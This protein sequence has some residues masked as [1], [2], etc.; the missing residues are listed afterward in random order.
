MKSRKFCIACVAVVLALSLCFAVACNHAH[1]Y[2][3]WGYNATEHWKECPDDG[4]ID[5][6]S[7]SA[8]NFG[9]DGKCT[10]GAEKASGGSQGGGTGGGGGSVSSG[11]ADDIKTD[12]TRPVSEHQGHN[13]VW[14]HDAMQHWK[15]CNDDNVADMTTYAAHTFNDGTCECG[16]TEHTDHDY[17]VWRHNASGHWKACSICG[18]AESATVTPHDFTDKKVCECGALEPV[19]YV[20]LEPD[21][22][23]NSPY[24]LVGQFGGVDRWTD[25]RGI[26]MEQDGSNWTITKELKV[27]D[28]WKIKKRGV[29]WDDW[30]IKFTATKNITAA[31]G[32]VGA[33]DKV[34]FKAGE[35]GNF[36]VNYNCT[37]TISHNGDAS[38]VNILVKSA[39]DVPENPTVYSYTFHI[40][41]PNWSNVH[42]HLW[43]PI[44]TG[45]WNDKPAMHNDGNGWWSY[46]YT[47]YEPLDET[48]EQGMVITNGTDSGQADWT[49]RI[50]M[51]GDDPG[52]GPGINLATDMWFKAGTNTQYNSKEAVPV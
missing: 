31:A 16:A 46:T 10:C 35:N 7:R 28:Q 44:S 42:I 29:I 39:E 30:E 48:A 5:E 52:H 27:G 9:V 51:G 37:V 14:Q 19:E 15:Y 4:E 47:S 41:A 3:K 20:P 2:T 34:L 32:V 8:H 45:D 43:G 50:T 49:N 11:P 1:Q 40:Y 26:G 36:V 33:V 24:I 12:P 21:P 13:L 17:S 22:N 38:A 18:A 6:T 23:P 25:A